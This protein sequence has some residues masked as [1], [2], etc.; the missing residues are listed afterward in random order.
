[1]GRF[2]CSICDKTINTSFRLRHNKSPKHVELS[3]CVVNRY[4]V[5]NN[6]VEDT[7][8]ILNEHINDYKKKFVKFKFICKISSI[9]IRDYPK[10]ILIKKY[11]F[12]LSDTI[13][14]QITF[15]TQLDNM[16]LDIFFNNQDQLL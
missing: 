4:N 16:T 12:K 5:D 14:L 10:H 6:K 11:K 7:N 13:N 2:Y 8:N 9:I 1:M 15:T 3:N